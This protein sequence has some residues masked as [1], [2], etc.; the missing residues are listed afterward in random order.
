MVALP[1]W[2][3]LGQ[4]LVEKVLTGGVLEYHPNLRNNDDN[5][6]LKVAFYSQKRQYSNRQLVTSIDS[7]P[8]NFNLPL[9]LSC[10]D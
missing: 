5:R 7:T 2:V 9:D 8:T 4:V 10:D 6:I 1:K 3:E